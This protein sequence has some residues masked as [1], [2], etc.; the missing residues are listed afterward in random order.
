MHN[1]YSRLK[2]ITME[3]KWIS[4]R[5]YLLSKPSYVILTVVVSPTLSGIFKSSEPYCEW[6]L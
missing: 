6:E 4:I 2:K 3:R 5:K 1:D